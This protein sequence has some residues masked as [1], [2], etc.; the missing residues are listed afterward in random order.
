MLSYLSPYITFFNFINELTHPNTKLYNTGNSIHI[1]PN[2]SGVKT[3]TGSHVSTNVQETERAAW[4]MYLSESN[5]LKT[6]R[7]CI[8]RGANRVPDETMQL[9]NTNSTTVYYLRKNQCWNASDRSGET[10]TGRLIIIITVPWMKT[11][12]VF[13]LHA[14]LLRDGFIKAVIKLSM[15]LTI[16]AYQK[17]CSLGI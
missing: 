7:R 9:N 2:R 11:L 3:Y 14:S 13:R 6:M 10:A 4:R 12:T 5:A 17:L 16:S 1:K 15:S 8:G